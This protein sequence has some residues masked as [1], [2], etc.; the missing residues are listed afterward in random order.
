MKRIA[1]VVIGWLVLQS[2]HSYADDEVKRAI[3][4]VHT[5]NSSQQKTLDAWLKNHPNF[6]VA[7]ID[8]CACD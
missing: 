4:A 8:E 1:W 5:L 6:R 2:I 3:P 7:G